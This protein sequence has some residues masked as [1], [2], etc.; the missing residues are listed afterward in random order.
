MI[1]EAQSLERNDFAEAAARARLASP[2]PE[3]AES[4]LK[5]LL[6]EEE[7]RVSEAIAFAEV[8][9]PVLSQRLALQ[10]P[11]PRPLAAPVPLARGRKPGHDENRGIADFIDDMLAQERIS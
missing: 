6:L 8:L 5:K 3:E 10:A 1:S 9:V 2:S 7:A 4:F 11:P